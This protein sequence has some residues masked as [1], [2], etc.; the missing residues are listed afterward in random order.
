MS[1]IFKYH[2]LNQK[3]QQHVEFSESYEVAF[4]MKEGEFWKHKT[5]TYFS[6]NKCDHDA[7]E[8]RWKKDY[9]GKAVKL[10]R[11]VYQ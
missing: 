6:K 2:E 10:T 11:I 9:S 3:Q 4:L 5:E 8:N 1:K 7:V